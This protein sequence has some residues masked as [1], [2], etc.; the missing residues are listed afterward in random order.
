MQM[1]KLHSLRIRCACAGICA[2]AYLYVS[3][4][5]LEGKI[6][7]VIYHHSASKSYII[8]L[9]SSHPP[10]PPLPSASLILHLHPPPLPQLPNHKRTPMHPKTPQLPS[11]PPR[12]TEIHIQVIHIRPAPPPIQIPPAHLRAQEDLP[13]IQCE[14]VE[15]PVQKRASDAQT[16]VFGQDVEGG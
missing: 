3:I 12:L 10:I 13:P 2:I 9:I 6:P 7:T 8:N 15:T 14:F 4:S 1:C 11:P 5:I 16:L